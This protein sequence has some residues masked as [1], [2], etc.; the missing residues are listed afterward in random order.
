MNAPRLPQL[1]LVLWQSPSG[2]LHLRRRCSGNGQPKNTHPVQVDRPQLVVLLTQPG[3]PYARI[4]PC[5]YDYV[6]KAMQS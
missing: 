5:A 1:P 2:R 3:D 4:C 6:R